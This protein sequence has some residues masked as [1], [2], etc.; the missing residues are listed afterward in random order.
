MEKLNINN[1]KAFLDKVNY[2]PIGIV[3]ENNA[4]LRLSPKEFFDK[5]IEKF[6][7]GDKTGCCL[8]YSTYLMA[9]YYNT[10]LLMCKDG[11]N[12][13]HCAV[14]YE[15]KGKL[16]VCDPAKSKI[17]NGEKSCYGTPIREYS[18]DNPDV[19]QEYSILPYFSPN[20]NYNRS[21]ILEILRPA[22]VIKVKFMNNLCQSDID[23]IIKD[24]TSNNSIYI[25]SGAPQLN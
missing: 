24:I 8:N 3:A 17:L 22:D 25:A 2:D 5:Q 1:Y 6:E 15:N 11:P 19:E 7:I 12:G 10:R 16:Y 21:M 4:N 9:K 14:I 13:I 20:K 23:D 18:F